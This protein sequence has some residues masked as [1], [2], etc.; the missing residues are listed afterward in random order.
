M[1]ALIEAGD[2]PVERAQLNQEISGQL[3]AGDVWAAN[4]PQSAEQGRRGVGA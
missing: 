3:P 1:E 2:A 4:R